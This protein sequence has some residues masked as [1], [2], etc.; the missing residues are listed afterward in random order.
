[1][2]DSPIISVIIP[3]RNR[4]QLLLRAVRSALAQTLSS[5]E[6]IVVVDGPDSITGKALAA[7]DDPRLV[8]V[9]LTNPVGGS[10]ARNVGARHAAGEYV[11]LL[12]DDDEWSEDKLERQLE[13]ARISKQ[14]FPVVTCRLF[15]RR[16][17]GE[18]IWPLRPMRPNEPVSEYLL[19]REASV[20]QGEGFMQSSTLLIPRRLLIEVPFTT[21]LARHQDWDWIIRVGSHPGVEFLWIWEPL[22]VYH[23]DEQ[24]K[25]ISAGRT[26]APSLNWINGNRLITPR[27]RAYFYA[28]QVAVRCNS[29][30]TLLSLARNTLGY[31]RAFCIAMGLAL[32]PRTLVQRLRPLSPIRR[33]SNV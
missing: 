25:S 18:E 14:P 4:P 3:T 17:G 12:D 31:P 10:E 27:A 5:I 8:V 2:S 20:R 6:V 19:C 24:R 32:V 33:P 1:M 13:L 30:S 22:V 21:G 28:T 26:L 11:A 9:S 16:P 15:A 29:M 7:V 23:I